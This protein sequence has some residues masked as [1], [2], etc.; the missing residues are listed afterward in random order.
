MKRFSKIYGFLIVVILVGCLST[1]N[2]DAA[3]P[4]INDYTSYPLFMTQQVAPNIA[5]ADWFA[6]RVENMEADPLVRLRIEGAIYDLRAHRVTDDVE[7]RAFAD[8]WTKNAW[9]R[10]PMQFDEVWLSGL[11]ARDW[12]PPGRPSPLLPRR[13]QRL[14]DGLWRRLR[15]RRRAVR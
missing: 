14:R 8:E 6:Q 1:P 2:A 7:M 9:A 11:S 10:D 15:L 5:M 4:S 13:L 12:P 3:E